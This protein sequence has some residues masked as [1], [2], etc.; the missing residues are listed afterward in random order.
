MPD[1]ESF[2]RPAPIVGF[3]HLPQNSE[4]ESALLG[5]ILHGNK[6]EI[7]D[8]LAPDDFAEISHRVI[9]SAIAE[10]R[11]AG[12]DP[13]VPTVGQRMDPRDVGVLHDLVAR[14]ISP[15]NAAHYA[16]CVRDNARRRR[17]IDLAGKIADAAHAGEDTAAMRRQ[18]AALSAP[19]T[20]RFRCVR[21][22]EVR[23]DFSVADYLVKG[24]LPREGV[25]VVWGPPKQGK[26]FWIYDVMMHVAQGIRYRGRRIQPGAVVY[27]CLEGEA[28][29]AKRATAYRIAR[30]PADDTPL[31]HIACGLDLVADAAAL[32]DAI[33][34]QTGGPV[35]IVIDTVNRSLAGSESSDED[36]ASYIRAADAIRAA[37][38]CL[39]VLVHH[40][41]HDSTRPRGH[42]SLIGAADAQISVK[43]DQA[44]CVVATVELAKDG[45]A[46]AEIFST[47]HVVEIGEDSDGE[48]VTSCVIE[49]AG[50]DADA[51][52]SSKLKGQK[53]L[54]MQAL[55]DKLNEI[56][57]VRPGQKRVVPLADWKSL[58]ASRRI[59]DPDNRDNFK[60]TFNRWVSELQALGMIDVCDPNVWLPGQPGQTGTTPGQT[61]W[62]EGVRGGTT[63]SPP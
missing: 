19:A 14:V 7:V 54:A 9:F 6:G 22:R 56:T 20:G 49:P 35:A 43:K 58:C 52:K 25:V 47:L 10:V 24:L 32:I 63:L 51:K 60:R 39:V 21:F 61:D 53:A 27:V 15:G 44:G 40:S 8:G 55:Y 62:A 4:A 17:E 50:A 3:R 41:G 34:R 33:R 16:E 11:A 31:Y 28:G 1:G 57:D 59:A 26:S 48:M 13:D 5:C 45:E 42:S 29:L 2:R 38:G 37:F 12:G 46:G 23:H 30:Q 18:L 36:M